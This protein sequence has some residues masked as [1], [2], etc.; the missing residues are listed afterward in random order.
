MLS[1]VTFAC[2]SGTTTSSQTNTASFS[3]RSTCDVVIGLDFK[4]KVMNAAG[5]AM[6]EYGS[7]IDGMNKF[8]YLSAPLIVKAIGNLCFMPLSVVIT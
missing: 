1:Y 4:Y 3:I 2:S 8:S 5:H 7:R 6:L